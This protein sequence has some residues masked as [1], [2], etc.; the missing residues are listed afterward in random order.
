MLHEVNPPRPLGAQTAQAVAPAGARF[1][2]D[3]SEIR[4]PLPADD[5]DDVPF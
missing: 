5:T 2:P 4:P 3:G 1:N